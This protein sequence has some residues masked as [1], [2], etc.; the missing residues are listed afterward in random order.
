MEYSKVKE[1]IKNVGI[2]EFRDL[3]EQIGED[4][5]NAGIECDIELENIEEAYQGEYDSDGDFTEQLLEDCGDIPKNI[6]NYIHIDWER[7]ARNIMFD[8]VED[9]NH[10]FR[11]L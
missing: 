9:D 2:D 6:P 4:V 5:I 7:T 10:Y 1:C 11:V 3:L 8:Y